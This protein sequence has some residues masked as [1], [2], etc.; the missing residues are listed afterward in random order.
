M[1]KRELERLYHCHKAHCCKCG[2]QLT[3]EMSLGDFF[4][5]DYDGNYYCMDC[6][7]EFSDY[8][9]RIFDMNPDGPYGVALH[10]FMPVVLEY[11]IPGGEETAVPDYIEFCT[12]DGKLYQ[13]DFNEIE[14]KRDENH[15]I[16]SLKDVW[17]RDLD[18][19]T[20]IL[21]NL[22]ISEILDS[23]KEITDI[24]WEEQE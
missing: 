9:E 18:S 15:V 21:N 10:G 5:L 6:D 8:D 12:I 2:C 13:L 19:D 20:E 16:A 17:L 7:D 22:E 11:E 23:Y 14:G 4:V 24:T 1:K 3:S